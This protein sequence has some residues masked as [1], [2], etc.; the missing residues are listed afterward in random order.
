MATDSSAMVL[1]EASVKLM[2]LKNP[3]GETVYRHG[4]PYT[5]I[6]ITKNII[7]ANPFLK[8]PPSMYTL[9]SD[10][11]GS[12]A[13]RLNSR[14]GISEALDRVAGVFKRYNPASPFTFK[15][16]DEEYG[17][18]FGNEQR[19]GRLA[20][21]FAA[22]AIFISCLGLFGLA[23]FVAEQRTKEIGIRKVLGASLGS[24]WGLLS[25]EFVVL[26]G[27][28]LLVA[29]PV[30][31]YFMH[32][33]LENYENHTGIPWWIFV[34]AG[35]GALVITMLTVSFQAVKAGLANPVKSL[36]SE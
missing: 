29:M 8:I 9:S 26:V 22:L 23:S 10:N 27:V 16:A 7:R 5:V 34:A 31:Y 25:R 24:V 20:S 1:N 33:W 13:I 12:I 18:K 32:R 11:V 35:A 28:S 4:K 19:I 2:G 15:F 6:G 17:K 14:L 30:S 36:R 3:V 21:F